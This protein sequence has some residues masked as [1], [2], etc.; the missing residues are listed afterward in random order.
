M[1]KKLNMAISC[2]YIHQYKF[3]WLRKIHTPPPNS[4]PPPPPPPPPPHTH[5]HTHIH[6][7]IYTTHTHPTPT[8]T[9]TCLQDVYIEEIWI[10]LLAV[11]GL[12]PFWYYETGFLAQ[13]IP[14]WTYHQQKIVFFEIHLMLNEL[15]CMKHTYVKI[16][17]RDFNIITSLLATLSKKVEN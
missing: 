7:H 2:R 14:P 10:I 13:Q 12:A 5:T 8:R 1:I 17:I 16:T 9:T 6:I 15:M 4:Y 3:T 11:N